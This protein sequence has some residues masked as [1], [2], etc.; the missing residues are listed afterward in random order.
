MRPHTSGKQSL[1][2]GIRGKK[3]PGK[4]ERRSGYNTPSGREGEE[5][6]LHREGEA[7]REMLRKV[8][9]SKRGLSTTIKQGSW[10]RRLQQSGRKDP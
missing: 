10:K 2:K 1:L 4:K 6:S 7:V 3:V 8:D 9:I 5:T